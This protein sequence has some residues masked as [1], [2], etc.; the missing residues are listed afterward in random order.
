M[1]GAHVPVVGISGSLTRPRVRTIPRT[2]YIMATVMPSSGHVALP[3]D[4]VLFLCRSSRRS[5]SGVGVV[6]VQNVW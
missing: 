6:V 3:R 5:S 4:D 1:V 2:P